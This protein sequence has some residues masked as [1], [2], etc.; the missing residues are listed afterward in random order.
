MIDRF[1]GIDVSKDT[2]DMYCS[3]SGEYWT[4]ANTT[5]GIDETVTR[6][7]ALEPN[8]IVLEATGGYEFKLA[9]A[10]CV[11]RLPV[12]LVNPRQVR[13]F[14]RALGKLAKTDKIDAEVIALFAEKMRPECRPL[15]SE[16]EQALKELITRRRQLVD[17]RTMESN[18]QEHI[19]SPLVNDSIDALIAYITSN[20]KDID[21][22]IKQ[23]IKASPLWRVKENLL[24]S[25]PGV[26]DGT[27]SLLLAALPELGFLN[28]R[29]IAALV[30]LAPINCDSGKSR[31]RRKIMGGRTAVRSQLYMATLSAIRWNPLIKK[32][33]DR[34]IAHGKIKKVA[35]T[36]CMRKMVILLNAVIRDSCPFQPIIT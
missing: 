7:T 15:P 29:Q 36:A 12:A 4:S 26:G 20:V 5:K 17:M 32:F 33:Y 28:R 27:A 19:C 14:A 2:F 9:A 34:L 10:L 24:K 6:L 13:N 3:P 25:V 18:R 8:C 21:R 11:A 35:M 1:I 31:G 30:G 22:E 23:L 16:K